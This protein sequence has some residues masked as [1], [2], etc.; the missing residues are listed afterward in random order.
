MSEAYIVQ[1]YINRLVQWYRSHANSSAVSG[2]V[3]VVCAGC[4]CRPEVDFYPA[5]VVHWSCNAGLALDYKG[6]EA[7][8]MLPHTY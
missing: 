6:G 1:V 2:G 7:Q 5:A 3:Y 4:A 8:G